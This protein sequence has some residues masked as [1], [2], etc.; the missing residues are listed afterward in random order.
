MCAKYL[1]TFF[2]LVWITEARDKIFKVTDYGAV[3]DGNKENTWSDACKWN[4]SA[5][6]LI[7]KGT[8]MLKSVVFNGPCHSSMTF[9]ITG[10]TLDGQGTA[11]RQK[12]N[13]DPNCQILFTT[14]D[15]DFINN[16]VIQNLHSVDSKGGHFIVFG[17]NNMTF[18]N[19]TISAPADNR[20]TD[21]IKISHTNGVT[22]TDVNIGTGDDC[23]AMI[24]G[25]KNVQ[26]SNV[27]CGPG[28]GISVGSLGKFDGAEVV[29][30]IS[31]KNCTFNGTLAGVQIKTWAAPLNTTQYASNFFYEDIVMTNVQRPIVIDQFYCPERNCDPKEN[32]Q[33]QISNATYKNI[34][35]SSAGNFAV[36]FN[37][38]RVNPCQNISVEDIN[39]SSDEKGKQITNFCSQV[40]G[41]SSGKQI[42][43]S[44]LPQHKFVETPFS[45]Q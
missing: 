34:Q 6:V 5:T 4:G 43:S 31:V 13:N 41:T 44:C 35:G 28:H 45:S 16:G 1:F 21:G 23:V 14:M 40:T 11:T 32:S 19:V 9:Q 10:G 20:N 42:P 27:F 15:L 25:T 3:G 18:T 12:C 17:S 36:T 8:F 37:C 29:E 39:F 26:I 30:D 2:L 38:S 33:V 7:P 22:I 24:A